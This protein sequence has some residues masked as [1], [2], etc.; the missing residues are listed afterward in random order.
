M[1]DGEPAWIAAILNI[2]KK[3]TLLRCTRHFENNDKNNLKDIGIHGSMKDVMLDV[4]FRENWLVDTENKLDVKEKMKN[5]ITLLSEM[6]QQ[7]LPTQLPQD[8]NEE[9]AAFINY[10]LYYLF[11]F[12]FIYLYIIYYYF[13][14]YSR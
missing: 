11:I 2:F 8:E 7:C 6:E 4:V 3:C 1:F 14:I 10:L 13:F 9:F 12:L 5:A